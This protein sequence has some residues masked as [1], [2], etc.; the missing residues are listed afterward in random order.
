MKRSFPQG[1]A[2]KKVSSSSCAE[3]KKILR[4]QNWM[5]FLL[6]VV[7]LGRNLRTATATSCVTGWVFGL[8]VLLG[9]VD[10][11]F[12]SALPAK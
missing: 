5:H 12:F 9:G 2:S 6:V 11:C 8:G 7:L 1:Q 4:G 3:S 10:F